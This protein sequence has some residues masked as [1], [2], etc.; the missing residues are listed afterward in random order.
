MPPASLKRVTSTDRDISPPPAKRRITANTTSA[1][2]NNFFKPLSQKEA[3]KVTFHTVQDSLLIARYQDA[4]IAERPKPVKIAAFDLDGTVIT[5][6]SGNKFARGADDWRWWHATVPTKM[7]ELNNDGYAVV[8]MSNQAAVSLQSDG[9]TAKGDMKSLNNIKAKITAVLNALDMPI[10]LYAAT[11][12]DLYRKPRTG[13]WDQ[14]L[15]DY[16]LADHGDIDHGLCIFVGDAAGREGDKAAGIKR[17]HSSSDRDFA[18]NVA[19]QFHTPEE[20]F[21]GEA[22]K[23]FVRGFEPAAYIDVPVTSETDRTPILF[24]K[25]HEVEL[26]LFCGSPGAGKSTFYWYTLQPLGYE[27]VNQDILKSRDKCMKVA[28]DFVEDGKSVVVDNTNADIETRATWIKMAHRLKVPVRLVHFT[29]SA[30]L[31]E[32]NDTVR[33]LSGGL[34]NPEQ[35]TILPRMAFTGFASRYR[36]P[37][38]EEGFEDITK[39]DFE[40]HGSDEQKAVWKRY[41]VS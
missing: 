4:L 27:R 11:T 12:H 41:W 22:V 5:T 7:K 17:D 40:F 18:A 35:R 6:K 36:E 26:V 8:I 31:C 34:M 19:I 23:P 28:T 9:K 21:L 3:E 10:S 13:M 15:K 1:A 30:K 2:V 33:A 20:F 25:K 16:S 24:T 14:L 38:V 32:H 39:V 37:K 29:A